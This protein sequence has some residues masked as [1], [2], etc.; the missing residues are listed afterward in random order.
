M[1]NRHVILVPGANFGP[2]Q[3]LLFMV[4]MAAWDRQHESTPLEWDNTRPTAEHSDAQRSQWVNDRVASAIAGR[5]DPE[6]LLA[7]KSLG[8]YAAVTAAERGLPAIWF[9]PLLNSP[10]IVSALKTAT[11]PFLLLG[12]TGDPS[13]NA[14]QARHLTPHIVEIADADHGLRVRDRP[15]AAYATD[16]ATMATAVEDFIDAVWQ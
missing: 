4:M 11:A 16:L 9:T 3:P 6:V 1:P 7:G 14:E 2:Y 8:S 5:P 12:G 10:T 15:L 13:W